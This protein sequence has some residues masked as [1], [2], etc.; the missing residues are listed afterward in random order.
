MC[1]L[2]RVFGSG[3]NRAGVLPRVREHQ[4]VVFGYSA[5]LCGALE[6][7]VATGGA[8][9]ETPRGGGPCLPLEPVIIVIIP[10]PTFPPTPADHARSTSVMLSPPRRLL[11]KLLLAAGSWEGTVIKRLGTAQSV[12]QWQHQGR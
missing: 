12:W 5:L 10:A 7:T 4:Q 6:V 2:P 1:E 11:H 3:T 9:S 8:C